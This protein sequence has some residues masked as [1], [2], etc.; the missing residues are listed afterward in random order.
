M[1]RLR[2]ATSMIGDDGRIHGDGSDERDSRGRGYKRARP[3]REISDPLGDPVHRR[4][5]RPGQGRPGLGHVPGR[6]GHLRGRSAGR[7]DPHR[8]VP[9]LHDVPDH[10]EDRLR[11]GPQGRQ[12][13]QARGPDALRQLGDQA[14]HDVRHRALVSGC[15]VSTI[16][17][18]GGGGLREDAPRARSGPWATH[19]AWA[20]S[21]WWTGSR[22]W[23]S[24]CG[25]ATWPGASCW[26]SLPAR[27]WCWCGA[28]WPGATTATRWSWSPS[29]RL[30]CSSSTGPLGGFLLGVGRLP[31][32]WQA[33][34]LSIGIYVALPLVAGYLSRK[35]IIRP[36]GK[37]GS[38]RSSCTC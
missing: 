7:V 28:S 1:I 17:R 26:A 37:T 33:L 10:G 27:P 29:I 36:R 25:A 2:L 35:W 30:Q 20:R 14:L 5:D 22:C 9:V 4:R 13:P 21:C 32:P 31:V 38:G 19:T 34:L 12:E 15:P 18:A 23:R 3:L 6:A 16:H 11:R 24:P 8:R